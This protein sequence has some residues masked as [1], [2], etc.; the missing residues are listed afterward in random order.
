MKITSQELRCL[1]THISK[2]IEPEI[3]EACVRERGLRQFCSLTAVWFVLLVAL[4]LLLL[5]LF[6]AFV[7]L[8]SLCCLW[9]RLLDWFAI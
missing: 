2:L 8:V 4:A 3:L 9:F 7:L 6:A 1:A 5:V